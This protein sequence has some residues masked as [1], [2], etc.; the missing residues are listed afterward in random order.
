MMNSDF[1]L[2]AAKA[3][4]ARILSEKGLDDE[5]R[6]SLAYRTCLGRAPSAS[7]KA[8]ALSF[9]KNDTGE[10]DAQGAWEGI[11]HGL[12]GCIDF[13]YLN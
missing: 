2:N 11:L 3:A 6:L 12:F 9:L 5:Q 1:V 8:L 10:T 7:E 13:R 4:A